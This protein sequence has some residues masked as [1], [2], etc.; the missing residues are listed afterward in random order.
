MTLQASVQRGL[1]QRRARGLNGCASNGALLNVKFAVA[2]NIQCAQNTYRL[3]AD[4]GADTITWENSYF[5]M[6]DN[7]FPYDENRFVSERNFSCAEKALVI[8]DSINM[9]K[10]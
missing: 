10:R 3:A 7:L 5:E 8:N 2:K 4:L 1:R 6:H 9:S